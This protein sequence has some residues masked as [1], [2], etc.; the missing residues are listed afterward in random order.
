MQLNVFINIYMIELAPLHC[1][2]T[3]AM[4][5][6]SIVLLA[7]RYKLHLEENACM[8]AT[9]LGEV[10]RKATVMLF[11]FYVLPDRISCWKVTWP[12]LTTFYPAGTWFSWQRPPNGILLIFFFFGH[13]PG[14]SFL[15]LKSWSILQQLLD[16]SRFF[17]SRSWVWTKTTHMYSLRWRLLP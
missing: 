17:W 10:E 9:E 3:G 14:I 13:D 2:W 15:A 8:I 16:F 1:T 7:W 4:C 6:M 12:D 5:T 11:I